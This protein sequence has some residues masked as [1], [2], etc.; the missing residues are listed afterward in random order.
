MNNT[1]HKF[2]NVVFDGTDANKADAAIIFVHGRGDASDGMHKLANYVVKKENV[3]LAFPKAT[4]ATWYP[5]SFL[6]PWDV[7][8][9]WLDSAL[10]NLANIVKHFNESG[11]ADENIYFL[12][13]SQGACL[14]LDYTARN[15]KKYGGIMALSGGLIGPHIDAS[16]Y[17]GNYEGTKVLLG[18]SDV[19]FHIPV[20]RVHDSEKMLLELGANVD[21]RIYPGM[22][23]LINDD[24][25]EAVIEILNG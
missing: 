24:E 21:K 11:V 15:A 18:C 13:F 22:G 17:S 16:K 10:D 4:N 8:Q 23:H 7:N 1:L 3:A 12:G 20:E 25:I 6:Q 14:A 9:P 5:A 2:E 19:D